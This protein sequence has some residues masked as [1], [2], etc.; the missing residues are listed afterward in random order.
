ML[1][2]DRAHQA[3]LGLGP[4][5]VRP[6][7]DDVACAIGNAV[8]RR[9]CG[10]RR[11]RRSDG[12]MRRRCAR[13]I[14]LVEREWRRRAAGGD[15]FDV[16]RSAGAGRRRGARRRRSAHGVHPRRCR[17]PVR[18]GLDHQDVHGTAPRRGD[19]ARRGGARRPDRRVH[20]PRRRP[21]GIRDVRGALGTPIGAAD[22][23]ERPVVAGAGGAGV[24]G[25]RGRRRRDGRGAPRRGIRRA[26]ATGCP[27]A[28]LEHGRRARRAG[29]RI[30]GG[31]R[32]LSH[33]HHRADLRAERHDRGGP[34]GR[35]RRS[36]RGTGTGLDRRRR[37][38]GTVDAGRVRS[39][40]RCG[41]DG[42]RSRRLRARRHR[43]SLRRVRRP[44]AAPGS[45][46]VGHR[47]LLGRLDGERARDRGAQR[48]DRRVREHPRH[49][50][51][52][53]AAIVLSNQG[54]IIDEVGAR[55]LRLADC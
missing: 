33:P 11:G 10:A 55:L 38:G 21:R 32:R 51:L 30:G 37:R 47:L 40:R 45:R 26:A 34:P 46:G 48:P 2:S 42:R 35:G 22:V 23:P 14:R 53:G 41:G 5:P 24:P 13:A 17:H 36:A 4:Q 20:R 3:T 7:A 49:R 39:G 50:P 12:R 43:R 54:R 6:G 28:V 44:R 18:D 1:R 52:G 9:D 25:R 31:R 8:S 27:A 19:R 29:A 15:P 16:H